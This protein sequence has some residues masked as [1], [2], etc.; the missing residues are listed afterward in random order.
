MELVDPIGVALVSHWIL[1]LGCLG[2]DDFPV[3]LRTRLPKGVG[4]GVLLNI[5]LLG[6]GSRRFNSE[7]VSVL[8][9]PLWS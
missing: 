8:Q 1:V 9:C 6:T 4:S 3:S 2:N 7:G 5:E